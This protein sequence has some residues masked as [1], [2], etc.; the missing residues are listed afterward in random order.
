MVLPTFLIGRSLNSDIF[1]RSTLAS[2]SYSNWPI[3][4]VP[5][6]KMSCSLLSAVNTSFGDRPLDCSRPG[7]ERDHDVTEFA[8]IRIWNRSARNSDQLCAQ[9]VQRNVVQL[10]FGHTIPGEAELQNRNGGRVVIDDQRR[11]RSGR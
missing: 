5:P 2:T 9:K 1:C 8:S 6:G 4:A 7:V 11:E 3:L 10:R